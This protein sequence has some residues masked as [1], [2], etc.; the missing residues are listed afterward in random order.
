[1]EICMEMLKFANSL[2]YV[3]SAL[4]NL[5]KRNCNERRVLSFDLNTNMPSQLEF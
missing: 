1:M 5:K 2:L 4:Y 3:Y